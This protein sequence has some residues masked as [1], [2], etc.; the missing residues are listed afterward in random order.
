MVLS[1]IR[2]AS[3]VNINNTVMNSERTVVLSA[4]RAESPVN[5][6]NTMREV[7]CCQPYEQRL[8]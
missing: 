6:N 1:A 5:I 7:W 3:P 8:L 2:A 4:I